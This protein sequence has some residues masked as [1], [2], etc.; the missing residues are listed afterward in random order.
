MAAVQQK[1]HLW[2][3]ESE[4][5]ATV[6]RCFRFEHRNYPSTSRNSIKRW[7]EQFKRTD[8]VSHWEDDGR[9]LVSDKLW[10]RVTTLN[11]VLTW[12]LTI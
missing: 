2:F 6:Q 12:R 11:G 1:A 10:K 9:P 7:Y 4:S 8:N 3:H 5:I